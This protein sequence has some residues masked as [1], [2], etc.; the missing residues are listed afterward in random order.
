MCVRVYTVPVL[1]I[2]TSLWKGRAL[3]LTVSLP[4]SLCLRQNA[5]EP[6]LVW[7][8]RHLLG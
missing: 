4:A 3:Q 5:V 1:G 6:R 8:L 2:E 7:R